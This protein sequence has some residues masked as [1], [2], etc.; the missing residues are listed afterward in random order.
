MD[1]VRYTEDK[2]N[3]EGN[4]REMEKGEGRNAGPRVKASKCTTENRVLQR[5][6]KEQ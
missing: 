4:S 6:S 3:E 2:D 5:G 1:R